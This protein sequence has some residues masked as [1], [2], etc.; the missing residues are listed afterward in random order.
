MK[1]DSPLVVAERRAYYQRDLLAKIMEKVQRAF[2][3]HKTLLISTD[4]T[5]RIAQARAA[6]FVLIS[7]LMDMKDKRTRDMVCRRMGRTMGE[8]TRLTKRGRELC[9]T[10]AHFRTKVDDLTVRLFKDRPAVEC[11]VDGRPL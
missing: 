4:P 5:R 2:S 9:G 10:D 8:V 3:V 1:E 6:M 11:S 7:D